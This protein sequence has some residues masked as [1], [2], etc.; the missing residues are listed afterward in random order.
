M[1]TQKSKYTSYLSFKLGDELF[2]ASTERVLSI[3]EITDITPVPHSPKYMKGIINLRGTVLPIIDTRVKFGL[4]PTTITNAT[5]IIVLEVA[6]DEQKIQLGALVDAVHAVL[7]INYE[8]LLPAPSIGS[9]Y[10][11]DFIDGVVDM[12]AGF[13]MLLNTDEIFGDSIDN[14]GTKLKEDAA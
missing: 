13:I 3:L 8:K 11:S 2:A 12:D 7:E 5:C 14:E 1:S 9:K 10:R 6:I 4:S